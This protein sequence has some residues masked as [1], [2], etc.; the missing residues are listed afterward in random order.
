MSNAYPRIHQHT[1]QVC[2]LSPMEE[3]ERIL[4]E[5]S[6]TALFVVTT[7]PN[8][9]TTD[10]FLGALIHRYGG[11]PANW[12]VYPVN[13]GFLVQAP[14]WIFQDDLHID[15]VFWGNL[16]V[17]IQPW[18]TLDNSNPL[19]QRRRVILTIHHFPVDFWHPHYFR[20]AL[21]GMGIMAGVPMEC[22][23]SGGRSAVQVI[24]DCHN[25]KL[26]PYFL[27]V[28]HKDRWTTCRIDMEGRPPLPP[29]QMPDN[30]PPPPPHLT[31]HHQRTQDH[32]HRLKI[33]RTCP[34][35]GD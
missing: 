16:H 7:I 29:P 4:V 32:H 22:I 21:A 15:E 5:L 33:T 20:Q 12:K 3:H 26:I 24:L 6:T 14:N 11:S 27:L 28:G 13:D 10:G 31:H 2:F 23:L 30:H 34:H 19:P 8:P 18:Q 1:T 17:F 35:G 25:T 9:W